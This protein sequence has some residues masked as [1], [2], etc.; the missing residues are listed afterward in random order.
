MR[1]EV[2]EQIIIDDRRSWRNANRFSLSIQM[3][4]LVL[5]LLLVCVVLVQVYSGVITTSVNAEALNKSVLICRNAAEIFT[6]TGDMNETARLLTDGGA[7]S[8]PISFDR[9]LN[10]TEPDS[11]W[12]T[13]EMTQREG[14]NDVKILDLNVTKNGETVYTL[15]V[16]AYAPE[17]GGDAVGE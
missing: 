7:A 8:S 16:M 11:S 15:S 13:L 14:E 5:L 4:S 10:V 17:K 3:I 1:E 12:L 6:A 9:Q 2:K